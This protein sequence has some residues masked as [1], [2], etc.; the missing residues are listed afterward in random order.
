M[1][2]FWDFL[3]D[4]NFEE[5]GYSDKRHNSHDIHILD[6]LQKNRRPDLWH[7]TKK[8]LNG[9]SLF[10]ELDWLKNKSFQTEDALSLHSRYLEKTGEGLKKT[11]SRYELQPRHLNS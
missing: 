8:S 11:E 10:L 2:R 4:I 5:P 3:W 1:Y 9:H 7:L 6:L